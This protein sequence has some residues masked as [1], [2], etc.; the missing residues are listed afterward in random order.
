MRLDPLARL[1]HKQQLCKEEPTEPV[2]SLRREPF[3]MHRE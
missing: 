1:A 2:Q 3:I